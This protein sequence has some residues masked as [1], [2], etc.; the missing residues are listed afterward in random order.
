MK[1]SPPQRIAGRAEEW[2][3]CCIQVQVL[4]RLSEMYE[5][6]PFLLGRWLRK[7]EAIQTVVPTSA[8]ALS[9]I[10]ALVE[11]FLFES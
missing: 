2:C 10:S 7:K 4:S 1:M 8:R 5:S 6:R 9:F 11:T 3:A